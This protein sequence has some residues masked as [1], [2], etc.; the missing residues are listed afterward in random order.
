MF[1]FSLQKGLH[2][3]I[4]IRSQIY[5]FIYFH[6]SQ[7]TPRNPLHIT[8]KLNNCAWSGRDKF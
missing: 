5:I 6:W 2:I 4:I 3:N 1:I 7:S 8:C